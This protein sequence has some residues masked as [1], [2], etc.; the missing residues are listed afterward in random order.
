MISKELITRVIEHNKP[1]RIGFDFLKSANDFYFIPA[2][3]F[4]PAHKDRTH[5]KTW[6]KHPELLQKVPHFNGEVCED[7]YGNIYGRFEGKTKG[8]CIKGAIQDGW[9]LLGQYTIP[10]IDR[11]YYD[12]LSEKEFSKSEKF[13]TAAF[14][15]S[16]FSNLRDARLMDNALVDTITEPENI[17]KFL[18]KICERSLQIIEGLGKTNCNGI[19]M[20][21]D[22][23]TQNRTF[24]SP[25]S[26][27]TIFKPAYK[28]IADAAHCNNMKFI[29]H[30]CGYIYDF[31]NDLI[32]AGIDVFQFDQIELY[33][34]DKLAR[35]FGDR[36]TFY[37]PIDI[38]KVLPTGNREYIE[39]T[40]LEMVNSFKSICHGSLIVKDYPSYRD[41]NVKEE[42]ADWARNVVL[43]NC[44]L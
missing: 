4:V 3:R 12:E 44:Q 18:N 37:S 19:F 20:C 30:S 41:I 5:L 17:Q 35:D 14:P 11:K 32:D 9:E 21:D 43:K 16:V 28:T 40:A 6:G 7:C 15:F 36:T 33:G 1:E 24:I 29:L 39:K 27:R 13:V 22:W 26:F 31:M 25:L 10:Q 23:G 42:W 34:C 2:A 8:E 38:Q